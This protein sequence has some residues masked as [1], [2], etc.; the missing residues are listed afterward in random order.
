MSDTYRHK[1]KGK[2]NAGVV[3][4]EVVKPHVRNCTCGWCKSNRK[5]FDKKRRKAAEQDEKNYESG[6][7]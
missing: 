5:F 7:Y 1:L 4:W 3:E 2:F 6:A